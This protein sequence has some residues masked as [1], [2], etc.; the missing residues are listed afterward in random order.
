VVKEAV[1][2]DEEK[3][4]NLYLSWGGQNTMASTP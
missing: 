4:N 1:R 3:R 2:T